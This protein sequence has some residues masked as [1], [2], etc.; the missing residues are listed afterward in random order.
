[1]GRR[2]FNYTPMR[3]IIFSPTAN[4]TI[5]FE[6]K[7][8]K[9]TDASLAKL[10]QLENMD[11]QSPTQNSTNTHP[12]PP[13]QMQYFVPFHSVPYRPPLPF[14]IELHPIKMY[15][16]ILRDKILNK[17]LQPLSSSAKK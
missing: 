17:I 7:D 13:L 15:P 2:S 11:S 4:N 8:Q 3:V 12:H 9:F 10:N 5:T 6:V 14:D 16:P 1:M